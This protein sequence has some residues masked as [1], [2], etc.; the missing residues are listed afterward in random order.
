MMNAFSPDPI[1]Q[2][3]CVTAQVQPDDVP[4]LATAGFRSI[5]NNRPDYEGGAGQPTSAQLEDA[6][7]KAGLEYRYLPV[8]PTG[9]TEEQA[10]NMASV[11]DDLPKPVVAFCR[12]GR[13]SAALY[14]MGKSG[15]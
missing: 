4:A 2:A 12:T 5:V 13:R 1:D 9:H 7:R 15:T 11:V 10:R 8:P 6:A 14:R 3:L